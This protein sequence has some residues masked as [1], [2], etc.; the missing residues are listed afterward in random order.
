M[1]EA[2]LKFCSFAEGSLGST[3]VDYPEQD[4]ISNSYRDEVNYNNSEVTFLPNV[5]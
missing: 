3:D 2:V 5:R 1:G 4:F